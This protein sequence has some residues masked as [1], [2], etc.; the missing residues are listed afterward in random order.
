VRW[1]RTRRS[2]VVVIDGVLAVGAGALGGL[3]ATGAASAAAP[4]PGWSPTQA[5]L[6]S[7]PDAPSGTAAF[8]SFEGESCPSSVFCAAVGEYEDGTGNDHGLLEVYQ[9]GTWRGVEAPM[10]ANADPSQGEVF[11]KDVSCASVGSCVAIGSYKD[12]SGHAHALIETYAGGTWT[13]IEAPSP[14]DADGSFAFLKDVSCP[15]PGDCFAIGTYSN[16]S[17]D[18]GY[19]DTL[20]NGAWTSAPAPVPSGST[21]DPSA[22]S[23]SC[24]SPALCAATETNF[25]S[26]SATP[27][28]LDY[29]G[30]TWSG[31]LAPMPADAATDRQVSSVSCQ[32]GVC[33]AAGV[34][35]TS[36]PVQHGLLE[37][38]TAGSWTA[39]TAP[40]PANH[41]ASTPSA[42]LGTVSCTFDGACVAVGGYTDTNGN[43]QPLVESIVGGTA[44]PQEAS[45]PSDAATNPSA[46]LNAVSCLSGSACTAVG[47]YRTTTGALVGL[48]DQLSGGAWTATAAPLPS[49]AL[50]G[51]SESATLDVVSCSFRGACAAAGSYDV[52]S[53]VEQGLLESYTP[54][55]GYWTNAADGGVFTY[56]S[57]TF[58]GSAGNLKLNQP[59]VGM[60]ATPGNGGYWE[61]AKDGGIF[62]YGDA[63][64]YGSTGAIKLN[65]PIV[66][67][68]ATPDGG[69]YWLVAADGGIFNYGDAPFY[70][71]TGA[72]KLNQPI[73]G[74]AATPDGHGYW[75][76]ASDGGIFSYGDAA[77]FGSRG[78]Q[79]LNKPVVGMAATATGLGYWLV[80]SDGGI[81]TYGDAQFYGSTGAIKLNKPIVSMMSTFDGMGYFLV[82]SDGGIFNYGDAGFYGSAGSLHLNQPVVSG[83]P[84]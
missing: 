57:A 44:T 61:V 55:E 80:A 26:A 6:P 48:I 41:N 21:L 17:A 10:P 47:A 42:L 20:A 37:R 1:S 67:M 54:P 38:F 73:V 66:G 45:L 8:V 70:G 2:A 5:P 33:E 34:Y 25:F 65:Q 30:G 63:P 76:V 11:V 16:G 69:G 35:S 29:T 7:G 22:Q 40:L 68:A 19:I 64:F 84:S 14:S 3:F 31:V 27:V 50:S 59:V 74:M 46:S 78:G 82:A 13:P 79:A 51:S 18:L 75:L 81:F 53:S 28:L 71:S 49:N 62:S 58:H 32:A 72:I 77:F 43:Q 23:I 60:A 24:S 36:T 39:Q 52:P 12:S 83:A 9:G 15:A 56:G 4:S